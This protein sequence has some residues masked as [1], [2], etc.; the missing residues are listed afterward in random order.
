MPSIWY[1]LLSFLCLDCGIA[2]LFYKNLNKRR[3]AK[4]ILISTA[5]AVF[6]ETIVFN[7][8]AFSTRNLEM[9]ELNTNDNRSTKEAGECTILP[10]RDADYRRYG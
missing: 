8:D 3:L 4:A 5:C 7:Y 10:R 6:F 9:T 2:I 1:I